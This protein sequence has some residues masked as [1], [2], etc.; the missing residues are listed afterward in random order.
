[1]LGNEIMKGIPLLIK[2]MTIEV[3]D[4]NRTKDRI[5]GEEEPRRR[6]IIKVLILSVWVLNS[7]VIISG[8]VLE[9]VIM[10][11]VIIFFKCYF[12]GSNQHLYMQPGMVGGDK[13]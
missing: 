10:N 6:T 1:M 13:V 4:C 5:I 3:S 11:K 12:K 7:P 8:V 2:S 9:I